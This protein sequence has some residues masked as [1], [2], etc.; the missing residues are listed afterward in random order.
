MDA[1]V[2]EEKYT[3]EEKSQS[4]YSVY[5]IPVTMATSVSMLAVLHSIIFPAK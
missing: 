5:V 3:F 1:Y 4:Q 2:F